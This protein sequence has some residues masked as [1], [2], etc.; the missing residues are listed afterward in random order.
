MAVS[1]EEPVE[2]TEITT[3]VKETKTEPKLKRN[4]SAHLNPIHVTNTPSLLSRR[5]RTSFSLSS[6]ERRNVRREREGRQTS[7]PLDITGFKHLLF[8]VLIIGNVKMMLIDWSQ[9]GFLNTL[10]SFGFGARDLELSVLIALQSSLYLPASLFVQKVA[11]RMEEMGMSNPGCDVCLY[12]IQFI[13]CTLCMVCGS[14]LTWALI[15]HPLIAT[16]CELNV[17]VTF[18]KLTSFVLT[19]KELNAAWA[20]KTPVPDFYANGPHY[21]ENLTISNCLLFWLSP[22]LVYQPVYPRRPHV[23]W[24]RIPT[25]LCEIVLGVIL[26]WVLMIQIAYP[27]LAHLVSSI[28]DWRPCLEDMLTLAFVNVFI[29]LAGFAVL[30]HSVLNLAGELSRFSDRKF[31]SD[32]WNAGSVGTFWRDWNLPVSNYFRRHIYTPLRT[33]GVPRTVASNIVFFVSAL[34]HE[35]LFGVGTHNFNGVAFLCMIVQPILIIATAPLEKMR[36]PGTTVGNCVFW[37]S[38]MLGQPTAVIIYFLQW[39]STH[40]ES[41]TIASQRWF[42]MFTS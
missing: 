16:G 32:W 2:V 41:N 12:T 33:R 23:R 24:S 29:W 15:E 35:L 21:P 1:S 31:Y 36:G 14:S 19:N 18:L 6:A 9:F 8:L 17:I 39:V 38:I 7:R 34:L 20:Q 28:P 22:T 37:L 30:F 11:A 27:I 4:Y 5:M 3:F 26:I 25:L 42:H 10:K 40:Q 13:L